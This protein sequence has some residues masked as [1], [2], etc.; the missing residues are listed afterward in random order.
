[1]PYSANESPMLLPS[2]QSRAPR[3]VY[4]KPR[5]IRGLLY[6]SAASV[7]EAFQSMPASKE[8]QPREPSTRLVTYLVLVSTLRPALKNTSC[9]PADRGASIITRAA[10][11]SSVLFIGV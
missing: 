11:R 7:P 9:A 8:L 6:I 3:L 2:T 4:E 10:D 5:P 1:M